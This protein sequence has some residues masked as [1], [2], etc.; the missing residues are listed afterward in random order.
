MSETVSVQASLPKGLTL[1][2]VSAAEVH[3]AL[4]QL[5]N[6]HHIDT[7]NQYGDVYRFLIKTLFLSVEQASKSN[8]LDLITKQPALVAILVKALQGYVAIAEEEM[9][10]EQKPPSDRPA[11]P[12]LVPRAT[13]LRNMEFNSDN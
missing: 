12:R 3:E 5:I 9:A 4:I 7:A 1:R 11:R 8:Q 13:L 2:A 10:G 6:T